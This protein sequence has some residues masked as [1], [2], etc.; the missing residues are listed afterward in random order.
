MKSIYQTAANLGFD[1]RTLAYTNLAISYDIFTLFDANRS[2]IVCDAFLDF[3]EAFE[4]VWYEGL[5]YKLKC[6]RINGLLLLPS[7]NFFNR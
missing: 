4:R 3:S 1:L 7:T 2:S 6:N 5:L